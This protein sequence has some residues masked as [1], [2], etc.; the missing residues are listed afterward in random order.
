LDVDVLVQ[1]VH[2]I[3]HTGAEANI[4]TVVVAPRPPG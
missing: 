4:P 2:Q 1:I 3:V